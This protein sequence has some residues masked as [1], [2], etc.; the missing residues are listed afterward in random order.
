MELI[1]KFESLSKGDADIAGGKGASL[2]EMTQAGIPVPPGFVI[3]SESFEKFLEETDLNVEIDSVLHSVNHKEIHTVENASEKIQAL[4][5]AADMPEDI[6]VEIKKYFKVLNAKYVAVRSSAT[7]EDSASAAW[8]GQLDSFLNTTEKDLLEKVKRCWA[9]LFTPRA[10]FYRFEKELHKQKIS[11]AVVVQKMVES[12]V[13]GIAFSVHPVTQDYNQLIIEAGLGLGEAI[14][15]GQITPDSYVVEKQPRKIID[16]N[17]S[18]QARGIFRSERGG[19]EW[20]DVSREEGGKQT[21]TDK[22]ILELSEIILHIEKHYG[23]P[24]DIEWAFEKGKFYIVQSRPITTLTSEQKSVLP[25]WEKVLQRNF[26]PFAWSGGAVSEFNGFK[27][28]LLHWIRKRELHIRYK[29]VQSYM[30]QDPSAFYI[31]NINDLL[32]KEYPEFEKAIDEKNKDV[33]NAVRVNPGKTLSDLRELNELHTHMYGAMLVG[34]DIAIDIKAKI[35]SLIVDAKPGF[36]SYLVTP[37]DKTGVQ[38]E[39]EAISKAVKKSSDAII[40]K[41]VDDFGYLH[42]D[43]LG[44]PWNKEDYIKALGDKVSLQSGMEEDFDISKYSSHEQYLI[45]IFKKTIY[46][47]EEAR[48]AMVRAAWAIKETIGILGYDPEKLLYMTEREVGDFAAGKI[49]YISD[50]LFEKRKEA[51]AIYF[52]DGKYHE[53]TGNDEVWKLIQDQKIESFWNEKIENENTLKGAPAY[54]GKV[55][56]RVRLV[57]TQDDANKV[58]DGEILVSPMTQVEFLSGIRKC[59]AIVTD[60]GGIICHA[61]IVARELRKPCI[62]AVKNATQILKNGYEVEV[63]ADSGIVRI[64]KNED[65]ENYTLEKS[66]ERIK[67]NTQWYNK[68]Y[69]G[70]LFGIAEQG[71]AIAHSETFSLYAIPYGLAFSN[72]ARQDHW[73]WF[74]DSE[75]LIE[76]RNMILNAAYADSSF[77]GAFLKN[78]RKAWDIFIKTWDRCTKINFDALSTSEIREAL[79]PLHIAYISHAKQAYIVDTFLSDAKEDWLEQLIKQELGQNTSAEIIATLTA[80]VYESF[81]NE[82]E[83]GKL[84]IAEQIRKGK[85]KEKLLKKCEQLAE[86]FFWIRANYHSFKR[87]NTE[88]VYQEALEE[89]RKSGEEI[90]QKIKDEKTRIKENKKRKLALYREF[91]ASDKLKKTLEIS[92]IFTHLQDKRKEGVLRSNVLFHEGLAAAGE[93]LGKEKELMFYLTPVEFFD[94]EKFDAVNWDE[95]KTRQEKGALMIFCESTM[96]VLSREQYEKEIPVQHFFAATQEVKEVRGSVAYKGIVRGVARILHNI[97]EIERFNEGEV[98]VANQTTPEYVPAMKK[99][100]AFVT[101]QG[102]ITCHAAIVARE[103]KKPCIIGTKIATQVFKDG[104]MVEVDANSGVVRILK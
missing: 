66:L 44:K 6:A 95:I 61:A 20:K 39:Q 103:M 22:Q 72:Y 58:E 101:D 76:K 15:S 79:L 100:I 104:D 87:I 9:S 30:I 98:L 40:E 91:K 64:L 57:F 3:L 81:V 17:V 29:T 25:R 73:D 34:F 83:V 45:R 4:I 78:W 53:Y 96:Y 69:S 84:E 8:A 60:E 68:S 11:V 56:G 86:E 50:E 52:E 85:S 23:F 26:P 54:R 75:L 74:W 43:Y 59:A 70:Y 2:G 93:K 41:L 46:L 47:Y 5:L 21:M 97:S 33:Y 28:G 32:D 24:C 71:L 99:A 42:Q 49:P 88:Q 82:F 1:R 92:E 94:K 89:S 37:S 48:N 19:N 90:P 55:T 10:I 36:Q 35:D 51:F 27:I 102:G 18:L 13:S 62:I 80:P 12:E 7:A 63:D 16:K 77:A 65:G 38:R 67:I 14:V 31:S